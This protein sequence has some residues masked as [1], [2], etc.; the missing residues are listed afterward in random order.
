MVRYGPVEH[1]QQVAEHLT[2]VAFGLSLV[3]P[4]VITY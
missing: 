4:V 1:V 3:L 2:C